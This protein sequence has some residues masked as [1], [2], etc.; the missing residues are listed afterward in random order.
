MSHKYAVHLHITHDFPVDIKGIIEWAETNLSL[1]AE[2][3]NSEVICFEK[4]GALTPTEDEN[5]RSD[6]HKQLQEHHDTLTEE[7]EA[8]KLALPSR[9]KGDDLISW[10]QAKKAEI[11]AVTD[12]STLTE[13]QKKLWMG[14]D[15]TDAEK[16]ALGA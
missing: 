1:E 7:G 13:A 15:L 12:Y 8:A 14:L 9:L 2:S 5:F 3:W 10:T 6:E 4:D 16:D 11:A